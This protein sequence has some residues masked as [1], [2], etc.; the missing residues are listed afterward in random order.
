MKLKKIET[1]KQAIKALTNGRMQ[2]IS[3]KKFLKPSELSDEVKETV[4]QQAINQIK[5]RP[6]LN[7]N[8]NDALAM[9]FRKTET[10]DGLD[11][12]QKTVDISTILDPMQTYY[13][14]R[15]KKEV[16]ENPELKKKF[17]EFAN[18]V[19]NTADDSK[20]EKE[21]NDKFED[22]TKAN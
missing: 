11:L 22:K 16:K 14:N 21:I 8:L 12:I 17:E 6:I 9:L 3:A 5:Q 10:I 2:G 15:N 20:F 13:S 19:H 1:G 7:N 4:I 18:R